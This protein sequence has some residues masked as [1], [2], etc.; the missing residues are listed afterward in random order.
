MNLH[1]RIIQTS[2]RFKS[3]R[4]KNTDKI[5][6]NREHYCE[7]QRNISVFQTNISTLCGKYRIFRL[8]PQL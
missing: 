2:P 5:S 3:S 1:L 7:I 8:L 6:K 4:Y